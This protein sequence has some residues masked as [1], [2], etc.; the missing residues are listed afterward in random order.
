MTFLQIQ[1]DAL[2][3]LNSSQVEAR[4]R[5]KR[6]VNEWHRRICSEVGLEYLLRDGETTIS[7]V[8]GTNEY[9]LAAV[10]RKIRSIQDETNNITLLETTL[11]L[12]REMDPGEDA[13]GLPT[14]YAHRS[15][16]KIKLYPS[17]SANGTLT[18]D[19]EAQISDLD[20][21]S[22]T[23]NVPE[24]FHYLLSLGA[25]LNEYEKQDDRERLM[26]ARDEMK[27]G[28]D[29]LKYWVISRP[30]PVV[31]RGGDIGTSRL[32]GWYPSGT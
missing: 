8:A 29:K 20:D 2:E 1:N 25:R 11:P 12:L 13:T 9:T 23:P 22:D 26:Y 32:G 31:R 24:D 5:I 14:H 3:R 28:I 19:Y 16:R 10:V 30:R 17:P 21:D 4:S 7:V 27:R 15:D 18:V 6:F